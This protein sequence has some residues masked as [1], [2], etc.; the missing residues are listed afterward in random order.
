MNRRATV[1]LVLISV[2]M[3][4]WRS[5]AGAADV[6]ALFNYADRSDVHLVHSMHGP[7]N[8][9]GQLFSAPPAS[10]FY[11]DE[12]GRFRLIHV[13]RSGSF[14]QDQRRL[15]RQVFDGLPVL[16]DVG[17]QGYGQHQDQRDLIIA[18]H[19]GRPV[20]RSRGAPFSPGPGFM[21]SQS[22]ALSALTNGETDIRPD[23]NWYEIPNA[24]WYQ[25]WFSS[26]DGQHSSYMIFY[27]CWEQQDIMIYDAI[28]SGFPVEKSDERLIGNAR[29]YRLNRSRLDGAMEILPENP[30]SEV[31]VNLDAGV[32]LCRNQDAGGQSVSAIYSWYDDAAGTV[33]A[34]DWTP[35]IQ[36]VF[37]SRH[38]KIRFPVM[39][40]ANRMIVMGTDILHAWLH[41]GGLQHTVSECTFCLALPLDDRSAAFFIYS[42]P[43]NSLYRFYIDRDDV[44]DYRRASR[45]TPAFVPDAMTA[46][47]EGN[48]LLGSFS[49]WPPEMSESGDLLMS[50]EAV[51]L[52]PAPSDA[53]TT[54]GNMLLAQ[55]FY[56]NVYRL[57]P[58]G[59]EP[60]WLGRIDVGRHLY[61]CGFVIAERPLA[62]T[63]DV[64]ELLRLARLPG[65]QL[66][67]PKKLDESTYPGQFVM[68]GQV[69]M[70]LAR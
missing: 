54:R 26:V 31:V 51:E 15:Y 10:N 23:K 56:F 48:L 69:F 30:K 14:K 53:T 63:S 32:A 44:V 59:S 24:S 55:Q 25:S 34:A 62:L 9:Y 2:V 7:A 42:A 22:I 28:W 64:R 47:H 12:H 21:V 43:D 45:L 65:N 33:S 68:P 20:F 19:S 13:K 60:V 3:V 17:W 70:A 40:D 67:A 37:E 52:L 16:A 41:A 49:A 18:G 8:P 38:Q 27:D 46:D 61:Q 4:F 11:I 50:V 36:T 58:A 1:T 35:E 5:S 29:D 66:S 57:T 6:Y 39:H